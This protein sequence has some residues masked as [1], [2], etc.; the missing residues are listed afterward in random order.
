MNGID[1]LFLG[2]IAFLSSTLILLCST[3]D[4]YIRTRKFNK[5]GIVT[6]GEISGY[7][8]GDVPVYEGEPTC[9]YLYIDYNLENQEHTGVI[10][11]HLPYHKK[12]EEKYAKGTKKKIKVLKDKQL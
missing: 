3:L 7:K 11:I 10:N 12:A 6:Y 2:G 8:Y 9:D 5:Y 4:D 1:P